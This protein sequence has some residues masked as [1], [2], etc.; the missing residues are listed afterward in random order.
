MAK[1][2]TFA[3]KVAK[4]SIQHGKKCPKCGTVKQPILYV[5]SEP[6]KHG[7][8]RFSHRRIQVCQCNEKEVYG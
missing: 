1:A 6:S 4:A 8:V 5:S 2:K 7:S 3:D